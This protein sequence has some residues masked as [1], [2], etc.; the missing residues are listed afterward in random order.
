MQAPQLDKVTAMTARWRISLF[1]GF[2]FSFF[3][4]L[5]FCDNGRRGG[6]WDLGAANGGPVLNQASTELNSSQQKLAAPGRVGSYPPL[7]STCSKSMSIIDPSA[8]SQA[9]DLPCVARSSSSLSCPPSAE[10]P[11]GYR[12]YWLA[13]V[14][15]CWHCRHPGSE[16]ARIQWRQTEARVV[17]TDRPTWTG[18]AVTA[19]FCWH[20][21]PILLA[22]LPCPFKE[23]SRQRAK[24]ANATTPRAFPTPAISRR[25]PDFASAHLMSSDPHA[26]CGMPCR[27]S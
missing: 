26:K 19:H 1:G 5:G 14:L 2:F 17:L 12:A 25:A 24:N 13:L 15:A 27:P 3:W 8:A 22:A 4:F 16:Q 20:L 7:A 21:L 23:A 6:L 10:A 11:I 9:T 18:P